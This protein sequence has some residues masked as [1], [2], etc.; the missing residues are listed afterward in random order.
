M[1]AL[2]SQNSHNL[3]K[4]IDGPIR[5]PMPQLPFHRADVVANHSGIISTV[6]R[7]DNVV[8]HLLQGLD[9]HGDVKPYVDGALLAR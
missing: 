7:S 6:A 1:T 2:D 9:L 8:S 4:A 5:L 3:F